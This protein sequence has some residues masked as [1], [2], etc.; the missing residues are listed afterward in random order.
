MGR[1]LKLFFSVIALT[2]ALPSDAEETK[3][4]IVLL[5]G[6]QDKAPYH[7]GSLAQKLRGAR[8][9]VAA[10]EMPWSRNRIYDASCEDAMLE[11]DKAVEALKKD[12]ARK[13]VV[14]GLS[15][16]GSAAVAY[17]S[18]R[19][20]LA[21]IMVLAPG[22]FPEL[23]RPREIFASSVTRA[24]EMVAAGRGDSTDS[25]SDFNM[26]KIFNSRASAKNYL[27]YFDPNGPAVVP[28]NA[29]AIRSPI[30]ILWVVGTKD[31]V[32][33]PSSY[34]FDKAPSHPK[35]KYVAVDAGHLE[36]PAA[37]AEQVLAWLQSLDQ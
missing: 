12:G 23:Q 29:A 35:S 2:F 5:H 33:R 4:G 22:H 10:P 26:G 36:T 37:A 6:K 32:T 34:A 8:Y 21:G 18:R 3:L 20:N 11:I 15:L 1:Y 25:F 31:P 27:S 17:A 14:G 7:V 24:K 19:D 16:G 28:T 9:L 13:I 30:P